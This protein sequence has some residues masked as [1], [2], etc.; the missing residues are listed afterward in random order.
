MGL[1]L[2]L[3]NLYIPFKVTYDGPWAETEG[4][5]MT[6]NFFSLFFYF[7]WGLYPFFLFIPPLFLPF[8]VIMDTYIVI[9]IF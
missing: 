7:W 9:G 1:T 8:L 3:P 5:I 4:E 2:V 6:V